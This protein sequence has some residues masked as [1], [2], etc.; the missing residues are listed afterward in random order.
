MASNQVVD[1]DTL[2]IPLHV[3]KIDMDDEGT[4][5]SR[6]G[7]ASLE[8]LEDQVPQPLHAPSA[9]QSHRCAP[10]LARP[11]PIRS[12]LQAIS[13]LSRQDSASMRRIA[14]IRKTGGSKKW[15]IN[16][17]I[18]LTLLSCLSGGT[19]IY[20]WAAY[21]PLLKADD[22]YSSLCSN[23]TDGR[24]APNECPPQQ[25]ALTLVFT[26]AAVAFT[27]TLLPC[28]VLAD[29]LGPATTGLL[30]GVC[31]ACGISS[32]ILQKDALLLPGFVLIGVGIAFSYATALKSVFLVR[33]TQRT[34]MLAAINSLFDSSSLV[35]L[36]MNILQRVGLATTGSLF[37]AHS[38][39]VAVVFSLLSVGWVALLGGCRSDV[40]NA[41]G[42]KRE[43]IKDPRWSL[44]LR[45][46]LRE[47]DFRWLACFTAIHI[48]RLNLYFGSV[49]HDLLE[50]L[51]TVV[52]EA[53]RVALVV[54]LALIIK[55]L[56]GRGQRMRHG[57]R[58]INKIT[59]ALKLSNVTTEQHTRAGAITVTR[60]LRPRTRSVEATVPRFSPTCR[61]NRPRHTPAS[62]EK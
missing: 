4:L 43:T 60:R 1:C 61:C 46:I 10:S 20:G 22:F 34:L 5:G 16:S 21:E 14:T 56:E 2:T 11:C 40:A 42:S 62:H 33:S 30:A 12:S 18:V 19:L 13:V 48:F 44:S 35:P 24:A 53:A 27:T 3:V 28:G 6:G 37:A 31:L 9:P 45:E 39:L 52:V 7:G 8:L 59:L 54:D 15:L 57:S 51:R 55:K 50:L 41:G 17:Q 38:V 36:V 47:R 32:P 26:V 23:S 25:T 58:Q 29:R 49:S